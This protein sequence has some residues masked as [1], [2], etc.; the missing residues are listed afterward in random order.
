MEWKKE[1]YRYLVVA[2][3]LGFFL[4]EYVA[5]RTDQFYLFGF[6]VLSLIIAVII[7]FYGWN[8]GLAPEDVKQRVE[9]TNQGI[10]IILAPIGYGLSAVIFVMGIFAFFSPGRIDMTIGLIVFALILFALFRYVHISANK[11]IKQK[12]TEA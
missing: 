4:L 6:G 2:F 12:K 1:I 10:P 8:R 3:T 5:Y 11:H 9:W 7:L